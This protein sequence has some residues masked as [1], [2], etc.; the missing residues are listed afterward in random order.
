MVLTGT[1]RRVCHVGHVSCPETNT[2]QLVPREGATLSDPHQ[3]FWLPA[4]N[5]PRKRQLGFGCLANTQMAPL[6][7]RGGTRLLCLAGMPKYG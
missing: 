7:Q 2:G 3:T 4:G 6:S 1:L 5:S